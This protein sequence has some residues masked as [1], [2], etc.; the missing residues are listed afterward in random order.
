MRNDDRHVREVGRDIVN[1]HGVR[2]FELETAAARH[3]RTDARV[4][5]VENC[6]QLML[7]DDLVKLIG[8]SIVWE[9]TLQSGM[10]L[11]TLNY[12]GFDEVARFAHPHADRSRQRPSSCRRWQR[13]PP[14]LHH[15]QYACCRLRTRYRP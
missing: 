9:E 4:T 5:G 1:V 11:E 7:C 2:V 13:L 10:E 15:S 3:T 12:A 6:G 8:H 14:R